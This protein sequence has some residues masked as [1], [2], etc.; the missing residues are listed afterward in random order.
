MPLNDKQREYKRSWKNAKAAKSRKEVKCSIC[1]STILY[2][3]RGGNVQKICNECAP[4]SKWRSIAQRYGWSKSI[5]EAIYFEQDG[6]C[7]LKCGREARVVDH[8]HDTGVARALLCQGCNVAL[9]FFE[10]P[11]W[12]QKAAE[13]LKEYNNGTYEI[14][15]P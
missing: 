2:N 7:A 10:N 15:P 1:F 9:G 14:L 5:W 4:D 3:S 13:Y 12:S 8:S 6:Q 11:E